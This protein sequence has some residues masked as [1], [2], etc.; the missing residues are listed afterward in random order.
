MNAK[1]FGL[2][3]TATALFFHAGAVDAQA[4]TANLSVV[5]TLTTPAI[6]PASGINNA[7]ARVASLVAIA[8]MGT[9]ATWSYGAGMPGFGLSDNG[10]AHV[11]ASQKAFATIAAIAAICSALSAVVSIVGLR[12]KATDPHRVPKQ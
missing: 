12:P 11:V 1:H 3:L 2:W 6:P 10:T 9:I 7:V 4:Q 8:L 5:K